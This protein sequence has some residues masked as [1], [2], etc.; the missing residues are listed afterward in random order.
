[1]DIQPPYLPLQSIEIQRSSDLKINEEKFI[2]ASE[3]SPSKIVQELLQTLCSTPTSI[4][5]P[6]K[7]LFIEEPSEK[8]SFFCIGYQKSKIW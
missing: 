7:P 1:M 8:R 3:E 4:A 6:K 2:A 5:P